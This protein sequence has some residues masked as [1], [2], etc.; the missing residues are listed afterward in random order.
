MVRQILSFARGVEGERKFLHLR[1]VV[2]ELR[3]ILA[4][5]LPKSIEL[6]TWTPP[7]LW[8]TCG[9]ATQLHQMLMNLCVNSRDAMPTG[10]TLT[11]EASNTRLT[12]S[13]AALLGGVRPGPYVLLEVADTG[14]GI[15]SDI[16][17]TIF[18]P[19]VTT[20]R[21]GNG[22]GLGLSTVLGI[23]KGHG[24]AIQVL[25]EPGK[26]TRFLV[27]LPAAEAAE[28]LEPQA[29]AGGRA[30]K[31]EGQGEL[32]LVVDDEAVIRDILRRSLEA[33]GFQ[34]LVASNGREAL[35]I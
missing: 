29:E 12:G 26:G 9:D 23:V 10:G 4:S 30:K 11:I 7:D 18:D 33:A 3:K 5:T 28:S 16:L 19:F 34:I 21:S 14:T 6:S 25:S 17:D 22:T 15:P 31:Q 8:M 2:E 32:I 35:E 13:G 1:H 27:Y 20:K 24:G